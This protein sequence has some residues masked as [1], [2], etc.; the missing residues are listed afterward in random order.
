VI[1]KAIALGNFMSSSCYFSDNEFHPEPSLRTYYALAIAIVA[2]NRS[3]EEAYDAM[4]RA[5]S[6]HVGRL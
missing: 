1:K 4:Y 2:I 6:Y 3:S 5:A